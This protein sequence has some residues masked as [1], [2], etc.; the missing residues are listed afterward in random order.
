MRVNEPAADLALALA[1]ASAVSGVPLPE[2]L[3]AC[4]EVGLT[5]E[6]RHTGRLDR[7]LGEARRLGFRRAVVPA[8]APDGPDGMELV[9]VPTLGS[10]LSEFGLRLGR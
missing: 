8:S 7:R 10:A 5:G 9:R 4:G 2:D 3:V 6:V 1:L